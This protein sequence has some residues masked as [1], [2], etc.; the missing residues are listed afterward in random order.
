MNIFNADTFPYATAVSYF[1]IVPKAR[2]KKKQRR[3]LDA[4]CA[5]D[6]ETTNIDSI[7]NSVMYI[8]QFAFDNIGV[9][10]G[11][12]WEE[13]RAFLQ[14]L[15]DVL[16]ERWLIIYV[17]NL[18]FEFQF[19]QG[20]FEMSEEDVFAVESR[21]VLNCDIMEHFEFRCSYLQ[22]GM[23]LDTFTNEMDVK[24]KKLSGAEFDYNKLRYPW[25][26]LSDRELEY[27][28]N[29]VVGLVEAMKV[30]MSIEGDTLATVP[31]TSTG[32]VRRDVKRAL[33]RC[34]WVNKLQPD[35]D[36]YVLLREAFRGGNTHANRHYIGSPGAMFTL[37]NV[38]SRDIA[39]AYPS[40]QINRMFPVTPFKTVVNP[41]IE[42]AHKL[43]SYGRALLLRVTF[44]NIR[45]RDRAWGNPY[46]PKAKCYNITRVFDRFGYQ[47]D[48]ALYDNG[49]VLRAATLG[50]TVTDIDLQIIEEE[51]IYD[52]AEI[53][54]M[55]CAKYG[56]IPSVVL[57]VV[58]KYYHDKTELKDVPGRELFY[59]LSKAKLNSIYGMSAQNPVKIGSVYHAIKDE[60]GEIIKAHGR[61]LKSFEI[62]LSKTAAE[63]LMEHNEHLNFPYQWGVW[64]TAWCRRQLEDGLR[65]VHEHHDPFKCYYVYCDTDSIK[66]VDN[67]NV[68]SWDAYNSAQTRL[69]AANNA[70][71]V[72]KDGEAHPI[73]IFEE[74]QESVKFRTLGAKRYVQEYA[75]G[76]LKI[77]VAGVN[78]RRGAEELR[79]MGGVDAFEDNITFFD[80]GGTISKFNDCGSEDIEVDG[81]TLEVP[82]NVYI[83]ETTKT[84]SRAE[85]YVDINILCAMCTEYIEKTKREAW[86]W[87]ESDEYRQKS[88]TELKTSY[89][90]ETF[91]AGRTA[92]K[93]RAARRSKINAKDIK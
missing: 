28:I 32:Y 84:I 68:V 86:L 52:S 76:K 79:R 70:I 5:F 55:Q 67:D 65:L 16:G 90:Y 92:A 91:A 26:P 1:D 27:C 59:R 13:F 87:Q 34:K 69:S 61:V 50:I 75:D 88:R 93:F 62:D 72:S 18:S 54:I 38:K 33:Y 66:Y 58:R 35:F 8:W 9:I 20:Q 77:T 17:H 6:I 83:T 48:D 47:V 25:T 2:G 24:H 41:T 46:I 73:G 30:R 11:R 63:L 7:E 60:D 53:E 85:E 80:A 12:T 15:A 19:L 29:D 43:M 51:Y 31:K 82:P 36:T 81:H 40:A 74:E 39:S 3:I 10:I 78:K 22:T 64:T 56:R 89:W 42:T 44:Y 49:R 4:V 21:K 23:S 71:A 14:R 37:H 57:D 45:L